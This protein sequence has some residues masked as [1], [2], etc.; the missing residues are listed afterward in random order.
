MDARLA[1]RR[2]Q[3]WLK[4]RYGIRSEIMKTLISARVRS[5][6][7]AAIGQEETLDAVTRRAESQR[8]SDTDFLLPPNDG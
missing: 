7:S 6:N 2:S 8:T 3:K 1:Q 4:E 5:R